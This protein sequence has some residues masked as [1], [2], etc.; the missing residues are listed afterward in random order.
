MSPSIWTLLPCIGILQ[1]FIA[2]ELER[3]SQR[4][5]PMQHPVS[6]LPVSP[7]VSCYCFHFVGRSSIINTPEWELP[8]GRDFILSKDYMLCEGSGCNTGPFSFPSSSYAWLW[9][10]LSQWRPSADLACS[11]PFL[12]PAYP[13]KILNTVLLKYVRILQIAN[14]S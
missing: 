13:S 10:C 12:A 14:Y 5:A 11:D 7:K 6:S 1:V 3:H 4:S 9:T 8:G 2:A